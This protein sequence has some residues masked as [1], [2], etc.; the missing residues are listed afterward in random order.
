VTYHG[1]E[2]THEP[3]ISGRHMVK[4]LKATGW[5]PVRQHGDH[6]L[7]RKAGE[8]RDVVVPLH[9]QLAKGTEAAILREAG[10]HPDDLRRALGQ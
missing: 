8:R 1:P 10:L 4:V 5:E 2:M 9:H 7:L 6:L 3:V